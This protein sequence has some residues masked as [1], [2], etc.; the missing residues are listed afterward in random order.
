LYYKEPVWLLFAGFAATKMAFDWRTT[1]PADRTLSFIKRNLA[2]A[3]II[4][5][6]A[7]FPILF[8][9]VMFRNRDFAYVTNLQLPLSSSILKFL[10]VDALLLAFVVVFAIRILRL[11]RGSDEFDDFWDPLAVGAACYAVGI[12]GIRVFGPYY[13]APVDAIAVLYLLQLLRTW[14]AKTAAMRSII[15]AICFLITIQNMAYS[16]A[17]MTSRKNLEAGEIQLANFLS[18]YVQARNNGEVRI[19]FPYSGGYDLMELSAFL[20]YKGLPL[21]HDARSQQSSI[22]FES[23]LSFSQDRCVG[24]REDRCVHVN[25]PQK[26]DLIAELATDDVPEGG[27]FGNRCSELFA[28]RPF[29]VSPKTFHFF[30]ALKTVLFVYRTH[31]PRRWLQLHVYTSC[32]PN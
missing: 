23:S 9:I 16:F 30:E 26:G 15:A 3:G 27:F 5:L 31:L 19:F 4:A 8:V 20:D 11:L 18:K 17:Y 25:A 2:D 32:A 24:Y 13:M 22:V 28:Y 29:L 1:P 14:P 7:L 10:Q 12:V 21:Y 6:T